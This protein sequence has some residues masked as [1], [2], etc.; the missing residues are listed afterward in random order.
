MQKKIIQY[1]FLEPN[2]GLF[3]FICLLL[4]LP[5]CEEYTQDAYQE[6]VVLEA[7][8]V[9]NRPLPDVWISVT[10]PTDREYHF[11][12]AALPGAN[13]QII[14]LD[15]HGGEEETFGYMPS[16]ET[17]RYMSENKT[18][19]ILPRRTYRIDIDF[20]SRPEV[21]RAHTIIPDA[22]E[23]QNE[24][25][26]SIVY[27][28]SDQLE[29]IL[30][31]TEKTQSQNVYV[32]NS[33]ALNP[34]YDNL[35]PFWREL[36][37]EGETSIE[38]FYNHNT[39]LVNEGN[40]DI[41]PDGTITLFYPW[42]G[43]AFFEENLIVANSVDKNL[44]DLISSQDVQIGGSTLSPGEIPNLEYNISGGIGIF[45]GIASDTIQTYIERP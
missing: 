7:Y 16:S 20:N 9:A 26:G 27:Q 19:I 43:I 28:S 41:N 38:D 14:L 3:F 11:S 34:V 1:R 6:Y 42:V 21:L 13:I 31:A 2:T 17:G 30:S 29:I 45:G 32:F 39:P 15:E 10:M 5:A 25:P 40:F 18:H 33:I 12:S 22:F 35:A 37:N 44:S 23:I 36:V 8:A 4:M 24:I